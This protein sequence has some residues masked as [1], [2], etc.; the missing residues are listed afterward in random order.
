MT[1]ENQSLFPGTGAVIAVRFA[2]KNC[3]LMEK[4]RNL[5]CGRP[6]APAKQNPK[7]ALIYLSLARSLSLARR[8]RVGEKRVGAPRS[9]ASFSVHYSV[10]SSS[11]SRPPHYTQARRPLTRHAN[12]M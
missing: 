10:F 12:V 6:R 5:H 9:P 1:E 2:I 3:I 4:K 7:G 8:R 11:N